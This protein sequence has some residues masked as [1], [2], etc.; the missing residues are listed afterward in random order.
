[1]STQQNTEQLVQFNRE[2]I[3]FI[4]NVLVSL[5]TMI[6]NTNS[7]NTDILEKIVIAEQVIGARLDPEAASTGDSG[8]E[9]QG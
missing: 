8:G 9:G 4:E 7:D 5:R 2:E 6:D 3:V 1:M